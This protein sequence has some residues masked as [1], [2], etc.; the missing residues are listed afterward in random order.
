MK[1]ETAMDVIKTLVRT[2]DEQREELWQFV[3][4]A[5]PDAGGLNNPLEK[6]LKPARKQL[7]EWRDAAQ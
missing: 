7:R 3:L 5:E 1:E 6:Y 2:V 4:I